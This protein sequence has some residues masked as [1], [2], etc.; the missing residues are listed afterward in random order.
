MRSSN[1]KENKESLKIVAQHS[2]NSNIQKNHLK[3]V[4]F[5]KISL[6]PKRATPIN[7][8]NPQQEQVN[9]DLTIKGDSLIKHKLSFSA[10][11]YSLVHA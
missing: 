1:N 11:K 3:L 4:A 7:R 9:N 10:N 2:K 5:Q 8:K 6:A